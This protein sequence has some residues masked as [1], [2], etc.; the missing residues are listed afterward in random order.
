[1]PQHQTTEDRTAH[2]P[3]T[4]KLHRHKPHLSHAQTQNYI[5]MGLEAGA[6]IPAQCQEATFP[7]LYQPLVFP[8]PLFL[9]PSFSFPSPPLLSFS[10]IRLCGAGSALNSKEGSSCNT[11]LHISGSHNNASRCNILS[12]FCIV[13]M[14]MSC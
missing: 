7:K 2:E 4:A 10:K 3:M 12:H 14:T 5:I 9:F 6:F 13:Q 11:F 8:S 1:M